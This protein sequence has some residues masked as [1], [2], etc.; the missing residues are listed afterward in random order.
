MGEICRAVEWIDDPEIRRG[1]RLIAPAF[2]GKETVV[3]E[4]LTDI[5]DNTS[6]RGMV[7]VRY[8]VDRTFMLDVK[9]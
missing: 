6:L 4:V 9:S 3:G 2:F 1:G 7:G 8:Q 5:I